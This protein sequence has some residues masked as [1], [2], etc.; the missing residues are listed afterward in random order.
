MKCY[1]F[2]ATIIHTVIYRAI[3]DYASIVNY[4]VTLS[5]VKWR[6]LV[7]EKKENP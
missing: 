5:R 6:L 1:I 2:T 3:N 4:I 7:V